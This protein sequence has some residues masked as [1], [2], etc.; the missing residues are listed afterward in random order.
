MISPAIAAARAKLEEIERRMQTAGDDESNR[1]SAELERTT[2][3][4]ARE[5]ALSPADSAAK[6]QTLLTR[7]RRDLPPDNAPAVAD[8][9]L[10]E[11]AL[12]GIR[13]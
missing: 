6:L 5:P 8:Y 12:A 9:L 1:L 7:L 13:A 10:V 2:L 3:W 4:L 11:S